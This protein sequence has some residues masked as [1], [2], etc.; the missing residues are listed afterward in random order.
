M[1]H[2]DFENS[3]KPLDGVAGVPILVNTSFNG[4]QEPMVCGPRDA[5]RVF[6]GTGADLLVLGEFIISK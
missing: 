5:I 4:F 1:A 6:F 3:S 2:P